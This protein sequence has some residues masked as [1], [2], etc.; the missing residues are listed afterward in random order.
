M[1]AVREWLA[2]VQAG[3]SP[4]ER[5]FRVETLPTVLNAPMIGLFYYLILS[6]RANWAVINGVAESIFQFGAV[7]GP[8]FDYMIFLLALLGGFGVYCIVYFIASL[9][10]LDLLHKPVLNLLPLVFIVLMVLV[11]VLVFNINQRLDYSFLYFF[12]G[13]E[14]GLVVYMT[15]T[16]G[17][18][19]LIVMVVAGV[20][21]L[22]PQ[23]LISTGK[24]AGKRLHGKFLTIT[25]ACGVALVVPVMFLFVIYAPPTIIYWENI[26]VV[27]GRY[28]SWQ[29]P[30]AVA[31]LAVLAAGGVLLL[32]VARPAF[33]VRGRMAR[34]MQAARK[35]LL[36]ALAIDAGCQVVLVATHAAIIDAGVDVVNIGF[37]ATFLL[38]ACTYLFVITMVLVLS[39][40]V[41]GSRLNRLRPAFKEASKIVVLCGLVLPVF[42]FTFYQPLMGDTPAGDVQLPMHVVNLNNINVP[43]SGDD[44]LPDFHLQPPESREYLN[45]SGPWRV[46][47]A[48]PSTFDT[49][50][51]RTSRFLDRLE[52]GEQAPGHDDA[53][54]TVVDVPTSLVTYSM[55]DNQVRLVFL[56]EGMAYGVTWFRKAVTIP[57]TWENKSVTLRFLA[58]NHVTDTWIDGQ[59]VG[60]HEGAD[61]PFS[62]DVT[63]LMTPGQHVIAVRVDYPFND[64]RF[65]RKIIP[66]GGDFFAFMGIVRDV[67]LEAAPLAAIRRVD[68]RVTSMITV[69]HLI[70]DLDVDVDVIVRVPGVMATTG[71]TIA[72]S[73][74]PLVFPATSDLGSLETW[75][76]INWSTPVM[77]PVVQAVTLERMSNTGYAA[78]R[79]PVVLANVSLWSTKQ[80]NLH[81][82]VVNVTP[83]D[84]ALDPDSHVVQVGF[85]TIA[86][87]GSDLLLNGAPLKLAG[88][89]YIEQRYAPTFKNLSPGQYLSDFLLVNSTLANYLRTGSLKPAGYL[90]ADR[91]GFLI[92]EEGPLG[93]ANDINFFMAYSRGM[94][95]AIWVEICYE[96]YNHPS[97]MFYGICNEP[98]STIGLHRYLPDVRSLLSTLDPGRLVSFTAASSQSWNPAF[99]YLQCVT[100]NIYGGT[101]EGV[102][103]AWREEIAAACRA[104][105]RANPGK[106]VVV[107]EWGYWREADWRWGI[108]HGWA[109]YDNDTRQVECFEQGFEAFTDGS[110]AYASAVHG[111]VWFSGFDYYTSNYHNAMGI[112]GID[113][114]LR[115]PNVLTAMQA[116]YAAYTSTNL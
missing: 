44:V 51:P 108:E 87:S 111:F 93:W 30:L 102:K 50:A 106:P 86:V 43:F 20:P 46:R 116:R 70:G 97:V 115:S 94:V 10:R 67:Y 32:L 78:F 96:L 103:F 15:I 57:T 38:S 98:W 114:E 14:N 77:A 45:L 73:C 3:V 59:H 110:E 12:L 39:W 95:D 68:A 11:F 8:G 1:H 66:A 65:A 109:W 58:V 82:F 13:I 42:W 2:R 26:T 55:V 19:A 54:W 48:G 74:Y 34:G 88:I 36:V 6:N 25:T 33:L 18:F 85:R 7:F 81:A 29:D 40:R 9:V 41:L 64:P 49:L 107:M 5:R 79:C 63:T 22:W 99:D 105:T 47:Y 62:F 91:F 84:P 100:P 101:F 53:A 75:T 56:E 35:H 52:T 31:W 16:L 104:W 4:E 80:P 17:I 112:W 71:A 76:F 23:H 113:R 37:N 27:Q 24:H 83:S 28:F 90:V 89:T 69:D 21:A 92:W 60:Y 61:R 72:V